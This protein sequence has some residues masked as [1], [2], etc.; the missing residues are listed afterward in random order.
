MDPRR[1]DVR[2]LLAALILA[3]AFGAAAAEKKARP[4]NALY[5][6]IAYHA[7]SGAAGWAADR[8][9]SREARVEALKQ[10]GRDECVVVATVSRDCAALAASGQKHSVQKGATRQEAETKALARC[11]A[12]CSVAAWVCTR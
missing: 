7:A 8:R 3:C 5:G 2:L 6:A 9:T 4:K 12:A 1:H 11:G 10:C